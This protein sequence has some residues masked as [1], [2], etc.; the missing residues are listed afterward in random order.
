MP[1]I[2]PSPEYIKW[3][4][5]MKSKKNVEEM[6]KKLNSRIEIIFKK[7]IDLNDSNELYQLVDIIKELELK[8]LLDHVYIVREGKVLDKGDLYSLVGMRID[9][10]KIKKLYDVVSKLVDVVNKMK[11]IY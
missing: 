5:L 10:E 6:K 7:E 9:K 2:I 11:K 4:K 3:R 8:N 1:L